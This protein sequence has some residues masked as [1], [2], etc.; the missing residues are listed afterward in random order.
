MIKVAII[1]RKYNPFG[2]AERFIESLI[3]ALPKHRISISLI[4]ES[5]ADTTPNSVIAIRSQG[6]TRSQR[7][8]SFIRNTREA[9]ASKHFDLV[10]THERIPGSDIFRLGDGVHAAW[11]SRLTSQHGVFRNILKKLDPY[12][13]ELV[14][15]EALI[16]SNPKTKLVVTS[17]LVREELIQFYQ[18]PDERIEIIPNGIDTSKFRPPSK[19]EKKQARS[20]LRID[21]DARVVCFVG[22]DF[23]RK[24]L[25]PL[26]QA[27]G[28]SCDMQLIVVGED[29][30][31]KRL[32]NR[33]SNSKLASRVHFLGPQSN[34]VPLLWASDLFALPSLYDP[35][36]NAILEAMA[37]GLPII[38]TKG[39][40]N[41][42]VV[43]GAQCGQVCARDPDDLYQSLIFC[44]DTARM[45]QMSDNSRLTAQTFDQAYVLQKW[46]LFYDQ[47]MKSRHQYA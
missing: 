40:G 11:L 28:M 13:K 26:L 47:L 27:V 30:T 36:S 37:C 38:C 18:V 9:L 10:Q 21:A 16:M 39:T 12:H 29:K 4:T 5:W 31:A 2:G 24:G 15:Q 14:R 6:L 33:I 22:S 7:Y 45:E 42:E 20:S 19:N 3:K 1:R 41:A 23:E 34:V 35:S 8:K 46:L 44:S 17:D 25:W 32:K 43:V